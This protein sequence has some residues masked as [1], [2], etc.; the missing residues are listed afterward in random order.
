MTTIAANDAPA[1]PTRRVAMLRKK[2]NFKCLPAY[3]LIRRNTYINNNNNDR[4]MF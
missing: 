2:I 1:Y 3:N 4:Q